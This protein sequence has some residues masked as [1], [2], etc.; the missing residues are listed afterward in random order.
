MFQQM[1]PIPTSLPIAESRMRKASGRY[2]AE[3]DKKQVEMKILYLRD[4]KDVARNIRLLALLEMKKRHAVGTLS[5]R[6]V[7]RVSREIRAT[8]ESEGAVQKN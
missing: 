2:N 4:K 1:S 6:R 3:G 5:S 8:R 7:T